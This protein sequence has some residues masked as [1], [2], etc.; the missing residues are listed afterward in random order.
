MSL[1]DDS[2]STPRQRVLIYVHDAIARIG[3]KALLEGIPGFSVGV[4][5]KTNADFLQLLAVFNPTLAILCH[6]KGLGVALGRT[7]KASYPVVKVLL[8]EIPSNDIGVICSA[9]AAGIDGL[10]SS[11]IQEAQLRQAIYSVA[12]GAMWI[13]PALAKTYKEIAVCH[14]PSRLSAKQSLLD[15]LS[16]RESEVLA[17]LVQGMS[18]YD[19]GTKLQ[20]GKETVKTH[21]RHIFEKLGVTHRTEAAVKALNEGYVLERT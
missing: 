3:L 9:M 15:G 7:I 18:N 5:P 2:N 11:T 10:C 13:D 16:D 14:C 8:T 19:I 12:D 17:L 1:R 20:I 6:C 4:E 21:V